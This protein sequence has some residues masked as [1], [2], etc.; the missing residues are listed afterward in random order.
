MV[1]AAD[2]RWWF[3]DPQGKRT[4]QALDGGALRV[5]RH[6]E[7]EPRALAVGGQAG[8]GLHGAALAAYPAELTMIGVQTYFVAIHKV[9]AA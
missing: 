6:H 8:P 7:R 1:Q 4:V 2:G 5:G 3:I 9:K